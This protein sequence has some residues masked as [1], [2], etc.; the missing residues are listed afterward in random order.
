MQ[1]DP[2]VIALLIKAF[3]SL[4]AEQAFN[5][6]GKERLSP[7]LLKESSS[8]ATNAWTGLALWGNASNNA[9]LTTEATWMLSSEAQS[10]LAYWTNIDLSQPAYAGFSHQVVSL[11]WGGTSAS[12]ARNTQCRS[13]TRTLPSTSSS[14]TGDFPGW[15]LSS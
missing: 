15:L 1:S 11:N 2:G 14:S 8:E 13:G 7:L 10:T 4:P 12:W 5:P 3:C 6:V 9:A